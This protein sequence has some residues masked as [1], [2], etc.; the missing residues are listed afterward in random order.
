MKTIMVLAAACLSA[1]A[2]AQ[3]PSP[4]TYGDLQL[5]SGLDSP[6]NGEGF[7]WISSDGLRLYYTQGPGGNN[8]LRL[9]SRTS[10]TDQFTSSTVVLVGEAI[11]QTSCSLSADELTLWFTSF[12]AVRKATRATT[13]APWGASQAINI[14]DTPTYSKSPTLT[15]D[16]QQMVLSLDVDNVI[17]LERTGPMDYTYSGPVSSGVS[18]TGPCQMSADGLYLYFGATRNGHLIP[19]R[20]SRTSTTDPFGS[21]EYMEDAVFASGDNWFQCHAIPDGTVLFGTRNNDGM[22]TGDH[23]FSAT[24]S[25]GTGVPLTWAKVGQMD[26]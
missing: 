6:S 11:D 7:P 16:E 21:T 19:H 24:S 25:L 20:M 12:G 22:W 13:A 2:F 10:I 14:I 15:P 3:T 4:I 1:I 18:G 26:L 17:Y 5:L 9:A 23:L 8:H